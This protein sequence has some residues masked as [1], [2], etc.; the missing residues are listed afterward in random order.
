MTYYELLIR[1]PRY[2]AL[3]K[4]DTFGKFR[5]YLESLRE[6]KVSTIFPSLH[7]DGMQPRSMRHTD[8][9]SGIRFTL[10][11][12]VRNDV[13]SEF[14]DIVSVADNRGISTYFDGKFESVNIQQMCSWGEGTAV[15]VMDNTVGS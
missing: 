4:S 12:A 14:E 6:F 15:A 11:E 1:A 8:G 5:L 10:R 2:V 3:R 13:P 7:A 9:A